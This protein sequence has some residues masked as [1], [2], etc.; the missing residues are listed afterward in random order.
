MPLIPALGGQ[1]QAHFWVRGQ[2]GLQSEFQDSQGYRETLSQKN[3]KQKAIGDY[4]KKKKKEEENS[5]S[6]VVYTF[7]P[8]IGG[9]EAHLWISG[10]PD[11]QS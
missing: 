10:Q 11:L 6:V 9:A 8:S 7:N 3:K 5:Q 1:R 2:P 4:C